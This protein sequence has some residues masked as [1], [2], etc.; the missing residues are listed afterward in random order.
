MDE[1]IKYDRPNTV[2]GLIAKH[3]EI[4]RLRD[5]HRAEVKR[6]SAS[7]EQLSAVIALFDPSAETDEARTFAEKNKPPNRTGM[8]RFLLATLREAPEPIT[9]RQLAEQWARESG[10]SADRQTL[11]KIRNS[12]TYAIRESIK[13]G[14]VEC[15]GQT[16]AHGAYGPYK[17]WKIT[18][19]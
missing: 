14:L 4:A 3:R 7:L 18:K 10:T 9:S 16:T 12:V 8:K 19:N 11:N 13:Q 2:S 1:E 17:L 5:W 6:L 15:V